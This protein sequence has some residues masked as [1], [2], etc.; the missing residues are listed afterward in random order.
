ML[1]FA[2]ISLKMWLA[3]GAPPHTLLM[4]LQHSPDPKISNKS[5]GGGGG[6]V[7]GGGATSAS[8]FLLSHQRKDPKKVE[9]PCASPFYLYLLHCVSHL[10]AYN[11]FFFL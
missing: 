4:S 1:V 8:A 11:F 9:N 6:G 3:S 10:G 7:G 2:S 5:V